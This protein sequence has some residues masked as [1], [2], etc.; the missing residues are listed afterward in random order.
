[1]AEEFANGH[2]RRVLIVRSVHEG[3]PGVEHGRYASEY[4][5][6]VLERCGVPSN[7]VAVVYFSGVHRDRTMHSAL[8]AQR[9]FSDRHETVT[10]FDV[11]T[12]GPHARR[13]RLLYQRAFGK[14]ARVGIIALPDPDYDPRAWWHSSEGVREVLGESLAYAYARFLFWL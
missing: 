5:A 10:S 1:M 12:L 8:A 2:Y 13:S 3:E 9:W 14:S 6:V 11:V 4:L 7:A